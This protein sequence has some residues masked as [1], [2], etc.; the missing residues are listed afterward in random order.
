MQQEQQIDFSKSSGLLCTCGN[1]SF[2]EVFLFRKFSKF[3][4]NST[5][6]A[7]MPLPIYKCDKCDTVLEEAVPPQLR[8]FLKVGVED[9]Q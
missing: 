1:S 6:D 3:I 4:I 8:E 2:K 7:L 9:G 5:N